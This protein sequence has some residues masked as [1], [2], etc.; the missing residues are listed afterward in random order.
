MLQGG[1]S[2]A[3]CAKPRNHRH[4]CRLV[5][6]GLVFISDTTEVSVLFGQDVVLQQIPMK[7]LEFEPSG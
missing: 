5:L 1:A 6:T 7:D 2:E 3:S 4:A